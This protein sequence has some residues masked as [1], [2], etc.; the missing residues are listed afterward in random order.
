MPSYQYFFILS[1]V[2][3]L[4]QSFQRVSFMAALLTPQAV[5]DLTKPASQ[6]IIDLINAS[7]G[8]SLIPDSFS[9]SA[10][11]ESKLK[12]TNTKITLTPLQG[13]P[14]D[15]GS[16]TV[17][18]RRIPLNEII[19]NNQ[20][21]LDG[22]QLVHI[23]DLIPQLNAAYQI[24]LTTDDFI[25]G[26]IPAVLSQSE[27]V[28]IAANPQSLIYIGKAIVS[29]VLPSSLAHAYPSLT[30]SNTS[31][32]VDILAY[33][34]ENYPTRL[35]LTPELVTIG[36]PTAPTIS[37]PGYG[38]SISNVSNTNVVLTAVSNAGYTGEVTVNYNRLHLDDL[39][40]SLPGGVIELLSEF[41][42]TEDRIVE[43]VSKRF[44]I[45][46]AITDLTSISVPAMDIGDIDT[47]D[48]DAAPDSIGWM[49]TMS[50]NVLYGLPANIA[51]L[52]DFVNN[53]M[54]SAGY[55]QRTNMS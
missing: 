29:V 4:F 26:V 19:N 32:I 39:A 54:P 47:V 51:V 31:A 15:P 48:L 24:N 35:L 18:Y 38:G 49:G 3:P 40:S 41:P 50:V 7:N 1:Y 20:V 34:N 14:Y 2:V 45:P 22:N 44:H 17:K 53:I 42:F 11:S 23:A 25:D 36:L 10:P 33:I 5:Y 43:L 55:L 21:I 46:L 37:N 9:F 13:S 12:R 8:T 30:I 52:H 16:V 27:F 28:S 6:L